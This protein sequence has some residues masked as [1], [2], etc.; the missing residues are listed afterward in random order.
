MEHCKAHSSAGQ[1]QR[2]HRTLGGTSQH[3]K[4]IAWRGPA[5]RQPLLV[6]DDSPAPAHPCAA[7]SP[8]VR[9]WRNEPAPTSH[10]LATS[11]AHIAHHTSYAT[12]PRKQ[13]THSYAKWAHAAA[14]E[15][16]VG[17]RGLNARPQEERRRAQVPS[18][19]LAKS[20]PLLQAPCRLSCSNGGN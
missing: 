18:P 9:V 4:S 8:A 16:W 11:S 5:L 6:G 14:N 15:G 3:P 19:C 17:R 7:L 10:H 12:P 13:P 20:P 1:L 2:A